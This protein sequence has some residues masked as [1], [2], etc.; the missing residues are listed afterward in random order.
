M[1]YIP[2]KLAG[3]YN[4]AIAVLDDIQIL[5]T[6]VHNNLQRLSPSDFLELYNSRIAVICREMEVSLTHE[7]FFFAQLDELLDQRNLLIVLAL[8]QE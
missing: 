8:L 1:K 2:F 4:L 7:R 3:K 5:L 6:A